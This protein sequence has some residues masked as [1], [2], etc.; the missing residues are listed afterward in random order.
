MNDLKYKLLL[1][2]AHKDAIRTR[3]PFLFKHMMVASQ[4]R[5]L[6]VAKSLK[7]KPTIEV[8]FLLTIPGMWKLDYLFRLMQQNP[9]YHPYVVIYPYSQ[10]KGF[11]HDEVWKTIKRTEDF[12][13]ERGFE[14]IIPYDSERKKWL[15]IKKTNKPDIVFFTTPYRD[16]LPQYYIY[17]FKDCLTCYVPYAF[18]AINFYDTLYHI[19]SVN[20]FGFYFAET[21]IHQQY[22]RQYGRNGGTRA[23]APGYPGTEVYLHSDYVSHDVWKPQP[24]TKKR[25]IWAP[26]HTIGDSFNTSTFLE[27]CQLMLQLAEKYKDTVQ[28]AFKPHQLLRFKLIDLWGEERTTQYYNQWASMDNTQL[29]EAGYIDL[30]IH[31]DALIHDCG[32]FTTEYLFLNKPVMYL[33]KEDNIDDK[34]NTY[35]IKAY[36]QHYH[37]RNA[38]D[39]ERFVE[40]VV[41]KGED[42]MKDQRRQFFNEYLAPVDGMLPSQY[43]MNVLESAI[44]GEL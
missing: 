3:V 1:T 19:P 6:Q 30:F 26:H 5:T 9:K 31:S 32:S 11:S 10:Y 22:V 4:R 14:Y 39:I 44:N 17:N 8:A 2:L 12:I 29:E 21:K 13:K 18:N 25:I 35:G 27:N 37:G 24:V 36:Q 34:F 42:T 40:N 23:Y 38:S 15:D 41:I 28:F 43:I 7:D 16:V 33:Q 20:L